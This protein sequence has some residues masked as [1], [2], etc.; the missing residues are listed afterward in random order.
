MQ[1][2]QNKRNK[3][4]SPE[5]FQRRLNDARIILSCNSMSYRSSNPKL[6]IRTYTILENEVNFL[7]FMKNHLNIDRAYGKEERFVTQL[8]EFLIK[9]EEKKNMQIKS[10]SKREI[11]KLKK[12][13]KKDFEKSYSK[14]FKEK[15]NSTRKS[16][17][18]KTTPSKL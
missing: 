3:L 11:A 14:N 15:L 7:N 2:I 1:N 13:N 17:L 12:K 6:K 18:S 10:K 16:F 4:F 9:K 5:G 8:E